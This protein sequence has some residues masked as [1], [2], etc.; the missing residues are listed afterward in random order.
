MQWSKADISCIPWILSW[1]KYLV[2][3][4]SFR[5]AFHIPYFNRIY[6]LYE[7]A[8]D[9]WAL[10]SR[11]RLHYTNSVFL[12]YEFANVRKICINWEDF[13]TFTTSIGS[14]FCTKYSRSFDFWGNTLNIKTFL[15]F[16]F[17]CILRWYFSWFSC[18]CLNCRVPLL[19]EY[20]NV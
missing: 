2:Y 9:S 17:L 20:P 1:I 12:L 5:K 7:F 8:D 13:T 14:L 6:L 10:T 4:M 11:W 18:I 19:N 3:N 15:K 16:L